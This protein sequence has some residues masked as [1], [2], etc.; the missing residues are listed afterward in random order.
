MNNIDISQ[1]NLLKKKSSDSFHQQKKMIAQLLKGE[2]VM[3]EHCQQQIVMTPASN[4]HPLKLSCLKKCTDIEL[5]LS[6]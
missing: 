4:E 2:K 3:C 6:L 1:F 5:D